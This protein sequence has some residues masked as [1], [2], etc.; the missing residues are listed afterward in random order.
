M[1]QHLDVSCLID[2][3]KRLISNKLCIFSYVFAFL[4]LWIDIE[5]MIIFVNLAVTQE[6]QQPESI[7]NY[8]ENWWKIAYLLSLFSMAILLNYIYWLNIKNFVVKTRKIVLFASISLL[9]LIR[10]IVFI[11]IF[12]NSNNLKIQ[13]N[14]A[15]YNFFI[16]SNILSYSMLI[17]FFLYFFYYRYMFVNEYADGTLSNCEDKYFE[18]CV[19]GH[20]N[21]SREVADLQKKKYAELSTLDLE[22]LIDWVNLRSYKV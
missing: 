9:C 22:D 11:K 10:L 4:I 6:S 14:T 18:M 19:T 16:Y 1:L 20:Y 17:L 12:I 3:N 15:T 13:Y 21:T 8:N 5:F 7:S 2:R